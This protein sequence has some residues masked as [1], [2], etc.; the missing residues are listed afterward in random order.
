MA[1]WG[2]QT[3]SPAESPPWVSAGSQH[4]RQARVGTSGQAL[5]AYSN[6]ARR[7]DTWGE[8]RAPRQ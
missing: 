4:Q 1:A 2:R 3:S 6:Q 5:P 7:A 8:R